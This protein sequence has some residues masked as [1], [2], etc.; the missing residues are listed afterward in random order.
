MNKEK[1]VN[2]SAP[3][4]FAVWKVFIG[5][6]DWQLIAHSRPGYEMY[7]VTLLTRQKRMKFNG[8]NVDMSNYIT[9]IPS[10]IS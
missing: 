8:V 1:R 5:Q 3:L 9:Q 4:S 2:S 6:H 7:D 10:A